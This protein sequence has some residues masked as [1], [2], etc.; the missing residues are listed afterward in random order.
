MLNL[1]PGPVPLHP[2]VK[3]IFFDTFLSHRSKKF[4]DD[5]QAFRAE[6]CKYTNAENVG[7]F[8]GSGTLANEVVCANIAQISGKGIV[9][10]NGE[11]GK[12]LNIQAAQTNLDFIHYKKSLNEEFDYNEIEDII[13]KNNI[14]WLWMAHCETSSGLLND[15]ERIKE[16]CSKHNVKVCLDCVSSIGNLKPDLSGVYLASGTSGKGF[17]SY[18]GICMVYYATEA[19][20][21]SVQGVPRYFDLKYHHETAGI[22]WTM[23]TNLFYALTKAY[24]RTS[25][26]EHR[27]LIKKLSDMLCDELNKQGIPT[28]W[29]KEQILPGVITL[30]LPQH[31]NSYEFGYGLE[32]AGYYLNYGSYYLKETNMVQACLM[33]H[34]T[35]SGLQGFI[36]TVKTLLKKSNTPV[37]SLA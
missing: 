28:L 2:E 19:L 23:C 8:T 6:L 27:D 13:A 15:L 21:K 37:S 26:A 11:F 33:G 34:H 3:Q 25:T 32:T 1:M 35:E 7:L 12:R 14:S 17:A 9:L 18:A 31:I 20:S 24:S 30:V 16:L 29:K 4:T 5:M 36:D 10:N 22:P